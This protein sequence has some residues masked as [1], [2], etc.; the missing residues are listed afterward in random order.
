MNSP[1]P[2]CLI[3]V[4]RSC[5]PADFIIVILILIFS[6]PVFRA[7]VVNPKS[8]QIF[9]AKI[10]RASR[11]MQMQRTASVCSP[12]QPVLRTTSEA[13]NRV[14]N[15]TMLKTEK[16]KI[17]HRSTTFALCVLR[18]LLLRL[19]PLCSPCPVVNPKPVKYFFQKSH[20]KIRATMR[21]EAQRCENFH[22]QFWLRRSDAKT[23]CITLP[24]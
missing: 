24:C 5:Y 22:H 8:R 21:N 15:S 9:F 18:D 20:T 11:C 10:Q 13:K 14:Y 7:S 2:V 4:C 19:P 3:R 6:L 17:S 12:L 1:H 16:F 23:G